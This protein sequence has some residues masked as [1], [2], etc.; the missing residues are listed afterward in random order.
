MRLNPD[1]RDARGALQG[2]ADPDR[3]LKVHD[4]ENVFKVCAG[5]FQGPVFDTSCDEK[6]V[7]GELRAFACIRLCS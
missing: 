1:Y 3:I 5:N 2:F 6:P 7:V 4:G